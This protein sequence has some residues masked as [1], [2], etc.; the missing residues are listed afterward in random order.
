MGAASH[1]GTEPYYTQVP[2]QK[3]VLSIGSLNKGFLP[4]PILSN[5]SEELI[6]VL[7]EICAMLNT[8]NSGKNTF[9]RDAVIVYHDRLWLVVGQCKK[10]DPLLELPDV[11]LCTCIA[12]Q[13]F[14]TVIVADFPIH[15]FPALH[16]SRNLFNA[17]SRLLALKTHGLLDLL[18]WAAF[19]GSLAVDVPEHL[20]EWL[21]IIASIAGNLGIGTWEEAMPILKTFLWLEPRS[22]E[23][24][25]ATWLGVEALGII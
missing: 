14:S 10:V 1:F 24:G 22:R 13:F 5:L 6:G 16:S 8:A 15:A 2:P 11:N 19:M 18:F 7:D 4:Q 17:V 3:P 25:K 23:L 9:D 21:K 20:R 12:A